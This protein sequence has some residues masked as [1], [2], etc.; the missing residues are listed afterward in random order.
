MEQVISHEHSCRAY[1]MKDT[2]V[3]AVRKLGLRQKEVWQPIKA[4]L[5]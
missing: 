2:L 1:L 5:M 3:L 4:A